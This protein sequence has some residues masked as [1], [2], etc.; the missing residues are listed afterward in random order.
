MDMD[1]DMAATA[2]SSPVIGARN[3]EPPS[4]SALTTARGACLPACL[5]KFY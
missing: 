5:F 3:F 1:M 2:R 4:A